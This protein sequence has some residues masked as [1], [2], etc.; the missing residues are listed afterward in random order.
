MNKDKAIEVLIA[1]AEMEARTEES[2][3]SIEK[4]ETISLKEFSNQNRK[5]LREKSIE[6]F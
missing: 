5:W 3:R 2:I 4:G 1:Q 6:Q